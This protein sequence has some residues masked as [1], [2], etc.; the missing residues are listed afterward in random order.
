MP[1][2]LLLPKHIDLHIYRSYKDSFIRSPYFGILSLACCL[3]LLLEILLA[4]SITLST[5]FKLTHKPFCRSCITISVFVTSFFKQ[6]LTWTW[7]KRHF[8][9]DRWHWGYQVDLGSPK[10]SVD[11]SRKSTLFLGRDTSKTLACLIVIAGFHD[12]SSSRIDRQTVP[13]GYT[14]GWKSGGLNLPATKFIP[15]RVWNLKWTHT[16]AA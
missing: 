1:R 9:L 10:E 6:E 4:S 3:I 15:W 14:L 16:W 5:Y 11:W 8:G 7:Y 12:F 13:D 2:Y